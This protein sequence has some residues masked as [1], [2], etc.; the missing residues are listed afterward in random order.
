MATLT[1]TELEAVIDEV[2]KESARDGV[3]RFVLMNGASTDSS[4]AA[5]GLDRYVCY[6]T[7]AIQ[8]EAGVTR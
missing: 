8:F 1:R 5:D 3:V 4:A 6:S 7:G 2:S